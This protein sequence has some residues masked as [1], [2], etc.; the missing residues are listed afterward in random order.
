MTGCRNGHGDI[1]VDRDTIHLTHSAAEIAKDIV[2]AIITM[3]CFGTHRTAQIT[4]EVVA[5]VVYVS[6]I[7]HLAAFVAVGVAVAVVFVGTVVIGPGGPR[8]QRIV[9]IANGD[10]LA[11][12]LAT[13][14][15][16]VPQ[17]FAIVERR[18]ADGGDT[19]ADGHRGQGAAIGKRIIP[20]GGDA[21][22]DGHRGQG[23]A[24]GERIITNGG[25]AVT[26][27]HRG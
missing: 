23:G 18:V 13:G 19:V 21:V 2:G 16:D 24:S 9:A 12:F 22:T 20:D 11:V 4:V 17:G 25:D 26:D 6:V 7:P 10:V 14:V 27:G 1:G 15:V 3:S 5:I 8:R